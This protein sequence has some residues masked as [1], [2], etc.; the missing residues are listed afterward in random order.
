ML[1]PVSPIIYTTSFFTPPS[2][3]PLH[4]SAPFA[5]PLGVIHLVSSQDGMIFCRD[6][7]GKYIRI[8]RCPAV[9]VAAVAAVAAE[10][11]AATLVVRNPS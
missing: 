3:A 6:A 7:T 2:T 1:H 5:A 11:A 10:A 4:Q 9:A 8:P